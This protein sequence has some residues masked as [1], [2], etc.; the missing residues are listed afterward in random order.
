MRTYLFKTPTLLKRLYP[1]LVWDKSKEEGRKLYLTF[2]DGPI[3]EVTP[4][5]LQQLEK[6]DVKATFFVVGEN[7]KKYPDIFSEV[8]QMGHSIGNHTFNHLNGWKTRDQ[9]YIENVY[10]CSDIL[11]Q[12]GV[13]TNLFRPPYGKIR[14]DQIAVLK[15]SHQIIMWDYLTGDFDKTIS[16]EKVI[17]NFKKKV[18]DGSIIVFHDNVKSFE[19][20]KNSLPEFLQFFK[21]QDYNFVTL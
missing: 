3:P 14:R 8:L 10:E 6:A 19:V 15:S 4:W 20:L 16:V 11:K 9:S 18:M 7:V 12:N 5:I 17:K 1:D 21:E 2:D 13:E